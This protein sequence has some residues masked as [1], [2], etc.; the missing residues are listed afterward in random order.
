MRANASSRVA[1]VLAG[2]TLIS[3]MGVAACKRSGAAR[4]EGHWKG[5]RADGVSADAQT[6]AN[7]FATQTEIDVK[8]DVI[9]VVT[10]KEHQAGKYKV[11]KDDKTQ[12]V[13]ITDKDGADDAQTFTFVDDKT[14]KWNVL[15]GKTITFVRE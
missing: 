14:M 7:A 11:V 8:G 4:L 13:I 9:T 15:E 10:P 12:V 2:L 3:A 1:I 5:T 6:A